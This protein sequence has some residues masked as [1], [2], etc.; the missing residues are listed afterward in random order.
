LKNAIFITFDDRFSTLA[1]AC[2]RS[3]VRNYPKHPQ[4][5][6]YYDGT[7]ERVL[8]FLQ[9]IPNLKL[10]P[11]IEIP[12]ISDN[13]SLG[14]VGSATVYY[15]YFA[16]GDFFDDFDNVLYL[17]ADTL[18]LRP[19]DEILQVQEFFVVENREPTESVRV[20]SAN[21]LRDETLRVLL[22]QDKLPTMQEVADMCNAGVFVIP[23]KLR[24]RQCQQQLIEITNRYNRYL[25]YADQS[26]ISLWCRKNDIPFSTKVE[27]NYQVTFFNTE[28]QRRLRDVYV[29]HFSSPRKPNT[30]KFLKWE[31]IALPLRI[32]LSLLFLRYLIL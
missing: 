31:R 13:L 30:T 17:D 20:F 3:L 19:L 29:L 1:R 4:L 23:K 26:A 9:G 28:V 6:V 10:V 22:E 18:V 25:N 8:K 7:N 5:F 27:F 32:G 15:R 14:E 11:T 24:S 12:G 16:W 2:L 21:D